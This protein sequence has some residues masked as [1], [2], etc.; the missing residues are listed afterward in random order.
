M[1]RLQSGGAVLDLLPEVGGAVARFTVDGI[2]VLR[3]AR[4]GT[5]VP[6]ETACF[7]LVPPPP[8]ANRVAGGVFRF[9]G[10]DDPAAAQFRRPSACAARP[11]LAES[12]DRDF[13]DVRVRRPRLRSSRRRL[14]VD[15]PGRA[16]DR[17]VAARAAPG[18][19]A[20]QSQQG[21]HAGQCRLSSLFS[22]KARHDAS[23]RGRRRLA[24]RRDLHPDRA[25]G[26]VAFPGSG[27]RWRAGGCALRRSLPFR[28]VG[29]G[30]PF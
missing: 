15:L 1:A 23:R 26:A 25:G 12:V 17:A 7:P 5:R 13:A 4:P 6:L 18:T 14:A 24:E 21:C 3:P 30:R 19:H 22:A 20:R 28:M 27:A 11:G 10:P 29:A 8:F 2:D 16:E 9:G